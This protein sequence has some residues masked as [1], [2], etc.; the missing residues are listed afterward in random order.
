[1]TA[2]S[3]A[4]IT[5]IT[6]FV[7]SHLARRL[8]ADGAE[9]HAVIRAGARLER[10]PDL[11][12][13]VELHIDDGTAA[14]MRALV[15][16]TAADTCFHLATHFVAEH[17]PADV[18]P[19]IEANMAFPT[20][21]ADALV[22]RGDVAFVNVGTAWQHVDGQRRRPRNLYAA[23]K[24]A[25][26]DVLTFYSQQGGLGAVTV[27]LFDTYGPGDHRRKLLRA[28]LD[29]LRTGDPLAMSSGRQ[30]I[31]LV[32]VDD[33]VDALLR[34][35]PE[36]GVGTAYAASSGDPRTVRDVVDLLGQVAGRAV[37]VEW[38]T[39]PD[40]EAEMLEPWDAGP[41]VPGWQ[42]HIGLRAGFEELLSR[43]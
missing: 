14:G 17:T 37:P 2:T 32:H 31:D 1:M 20:R 29:A 39:R 27:Y 5:G 30:L 36:A 28:L 4:L 9:V 43:A 40:R 34:A 18:A 7:G 11:V 33:V 8:V 23:T 24:Q 42:P 15:D 21:L 16:R 38:G 12:E 41:T 25:F 13:R 3:R 6:G 35:V 26:E 22:A 10:V 19:M